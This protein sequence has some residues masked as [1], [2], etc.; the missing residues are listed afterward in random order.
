MINMADHYH[1]VQGMTEDRARSLIQGRHYDIIIE[2]S[3]FT[4]DSGIALLAQRCAPIQCH[5][6]GYH[7]STGLSTIDYFIGDHEVTPPEFSD[8]FSERLVR[9]PRPWLAYNLRSTMPHA[10][11]IAK[12]PRPILGSFNQ[13]TKVRKETLDY[14][15][16][17]L[18][19]LPMAVLAMKDRGVYNESTKDR[20][21]EHLSSYSV[22][23]ER[24]LFYPPVSSYEEHLDCYNGIDVALDTTPWSSSTTAFE[25]IGMGVPLVA[26]RGDCTSARMSSSIVIGAGHPEWRASNPE[27]FADIVSDLCSDLRGLRNSKAKLQ[28]QALDSSLFDGVT[29][30]KHLEGLF[31]DMI[32]CL[33]SNQRL[34][35]DDGQTL[36]S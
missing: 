32:D 29:L 6:I 7:A 15:G 18:K 11:S 30:T 13:L 31:R 8:Q 10:S 36:T 27:E 23:P 1:S 5:Y 34:P 4:Q 26:I 9:L 25:A 22:D 20:I 17:A 14:W 3:G 33:V 28:R 12:S 2:T 19:Q 24:I 16:L 21:R 35:L